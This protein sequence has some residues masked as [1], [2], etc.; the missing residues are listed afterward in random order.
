MKILK[1]LGKSNTKRDKLF[2]AKKPGKRKSKSGK[3]YYE[4]RRNRADL[5][6][7]KFL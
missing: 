6:F 1:L 2:R 4:Y 7:R 3:T 5:D